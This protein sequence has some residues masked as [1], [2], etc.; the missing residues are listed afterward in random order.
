[1]AQGLEPSGIEVDLPRPAGDRASARPPGSLA[2]LFEGDEGS[3]AARA[4]RLA[5]AWGPGVLSTPIAPP[6]W[7]RYPFGRQDVALRV[8]VPVDDLPAAVYALSDAAGGPVPIRGSA[9]LGNVHAVLPGT[10]P[11]ERLEGLLDSMRHVLMARAGRV[12]V[13][14]AP[15]DLAGRIDMATR[16]DLF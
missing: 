2:A 10:V 3:V 6:W 13:V 4:D 15:P 7:G 14:A 16:R 12:V 9:G 8:S 11:Q 1:L 5:K